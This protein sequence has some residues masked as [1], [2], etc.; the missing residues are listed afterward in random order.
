MLGNM[1][2]S[3]ES[4]IPKTLNIFPS[5]EAGMVLDTMLLI[6]TAFVLMKRSIE[7]PV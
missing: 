1:K 5:S 2:A 6:A 3:I 4:T 7:V